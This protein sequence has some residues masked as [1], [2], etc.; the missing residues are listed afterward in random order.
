MG[1]LQSM[2]RTSEEAVSPTDTSLPNEPGKETPTVQRVYSTYSWISSETKQT[3]N[4]NYRVEGPENG[5]PI[6]LVHGFGANINHFRFQFPALVK[7]GYRVYAIDL[8]G[9][10]ASPK[11]SDEDY[12]IELWTDL[13]VDFVQDMSKSSSKSGSSW[14]IGG[15]SIGGLV[16]LNAS[17]RLGKED[18]VKGCVLFNSSGGMSIFRYSEYPKYAYPLLWFMQNVVLGPYLGGRYFD[19]FRTR[20]NVETILKTQGVSNILSFSLFMSVTYIL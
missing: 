19:N 18:L 10:G 20:K 1:P 12:S 13:V 11:P 9:F 16:S 2:T 3:H 17:K 4:I 14:V 7:E 8:L 15:N 6:L 5:T